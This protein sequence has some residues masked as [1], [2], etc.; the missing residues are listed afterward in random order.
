MNFKLNDMKKYRILIILLLGAFAFS[1]CLKEEVDLFG[2]TSSERLDDAQ[3]YYNELLTAAPNGWVLEYIA[4]DAD[5]N[6]KGA[7][8]F[9]LKFEDDK[10]TIA[11][12]DLALSEVKPS[13]T[14]PYETVTSLYKFDQDMSVT[15]SFSTYNAFI[16]FFHEQHGSYVTHKGDFEFTIMEGYEDLFILRGKKYGN[17]MEMHRM[18]EDVT[19]EEYLEKVNE[20]IDKCNIYTSFEV[21]KDGQNIGSASINLNN[22]YTFDLDNDEKEASNV[23]FTATGIKFVDPLDIHGN[24][25]Q[26][27]AWNDTEKFYETSDGINLRLVPVISPTYLYYEQFLGEFEM[28]YSGG[29]TRTVT[30]EEKVRGKSF[31]MK[32]LIQFD[33]ELLYDKTTGTVAILTQDV[34]T[35]NQLTVTVCPWDAVEGYYTWAVG[36]GLVS[37]LNVNKFQEEGVVQFTLVDN[38][39]WSRDATGLLVRLFSSTLGSHGSATSEGNYTAGGEYR[40]YNISFTKQ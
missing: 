23:L 29:Q 35:Y 4:G 24:E 1:S 17:I 12:D 11:I 6:R 3:K 14:D 31:V 27:M 21:L 26:E 16:H 32:D 28:S 22:R 20:T 15:L 13:Y 34:G 9:L 39:V 19:W 18:P 38:G 2:K 25:V 33:V 7:Y 40:F 5:N 30:I 37:V 36:Y 8:N 10:V